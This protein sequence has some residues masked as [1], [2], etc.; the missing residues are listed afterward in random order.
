MELGKETPFAQAK[1]TS[2]VTTEVLTSFA[3]F[4]AELFHLPITEKGLNL[5]YDRFSEFPGIV[6]TQRQGGPRRLPRRGIGR[7]QNVFLVCES[8]DCCVSDD[9][10]GPTSE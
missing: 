3:V 8:W 7:T 1:E 6:G 10:N 9:V 4:K 2:V 5:S